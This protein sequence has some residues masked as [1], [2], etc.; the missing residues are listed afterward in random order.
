MKAMADRIKE[1]RGALGY[2]Q[3]DFAEKIELSASSY[4][5]IENAF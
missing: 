4:T 3:E 5:K 1:R 2:T